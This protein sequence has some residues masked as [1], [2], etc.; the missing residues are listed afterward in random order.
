MLGVEGMQ[1]RGASP[2]WRVH[3]HLHCP[4]VELEA[5]TV[6]AV[7]VNTGQQ[8]QSE[9]RWAVD[10]YDM[11][12]MVDDVSVPGATCL[13]ASRETIDDER[14]SSLLGVLPPA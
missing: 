5:H 3:P 2:R 14:S 9:P 11:A 6:T 8:H 1:A 12:E 7:G 10:I 4:V 13:T